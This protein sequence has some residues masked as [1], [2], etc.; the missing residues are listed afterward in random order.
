VSDMKLIIENWRQYREERPA[1]NEAVTV[2]TLKRLVSHIIQ[3]K[4]GIEAGD[5]A[6]DAGGSMLSAFVNTLTLGASGTAKGV[7]DGAVS[8]AKLAPLAKAG[9][10]PDKATEKAPFLDVF[11]IS[12]EYS[13]ILDDRLENAFVN[14]LANELDTG[15]LDRVDL[16][17]WDVNAYL[18]DWLKAKFNDKTVV[19]APPN[20]ID[21]DRMQQAL[22]TLKKS[23]AWQAFKSFVSS[24]AG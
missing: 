14:H 11:N 19:G 9:R 4:K 22:G 21:T 1:L 5:I 16:A 3:I 7:L 13:Q 18:E 17:T 10:L 24:A 2:D 23:G 15:S 12:D 8:A 20:Q 6:A